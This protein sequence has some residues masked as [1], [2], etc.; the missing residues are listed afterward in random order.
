M[1]STFEG[2]PDK[3]VIALARLRLSK[4]K[5]RLPCTTR[6]HAIAILR[7]LKPAQDK[8]TPFVPLRSCIGQE[9]RCNKCHQPIASDAAEHT[10]C[11]IFSRALDHVKSFEPGQRVILR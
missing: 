11:P 3:P 4:T 10:V 9:R 2:I 6:A 8:A 1:H 7:G 5:L